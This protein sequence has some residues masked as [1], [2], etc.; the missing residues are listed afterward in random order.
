[1]NLDK[2]IKNY[3]FRI[4]ES[5]T[6]SH[7]EKFNKTDL[8][9]IKK[10]FSYGRCEFLLKSS[11]LFNKLPNDEQKK[12][13]NIVK[14]RN[15]NSLNIFNDFLILAKALTQKK[16]EFIPLKGIHLQ[17]LVYRNINLRPIRDIDLL[18][19][20]NDLEVFLSC[21]FS[22]G[23]R[24]KNIDLELNEFCNSD[25]HYDLPVLINDSGTHVETHLRI[26]DET[27]NSLIHCKKNQRKFSE[28]LNIS[29]MSYEDLLIHIA[30][31]ATI[32]NGFDN[33]VISIIDAVEILKNK[34]IDFQILF[35]NAEALGLTKNINLLLTIINNRFYSVDLSK[36]I[37]LEINDEMLDNYEDL[38]LYNHADD[39]S[40][41]LFNKKNKL[42]SFSKSAFIY[43]SGRK[44]IS[45]FFI[46]K[47]FLRISFGFIKTVFFLIFYR[48]YRIDALRVS[49]LYRFLEK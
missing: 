46:L 34:D 39:Y 8:K 43:E 38:I 2:H 10:V 29:F 26:I 48:K 49:N 22:L 20:E 9:T 28:Q 30:F 14:A 42:K 36:K 41:K 13:N 44:N 11:S 37:N 47:R 40:F 21:M 18:I 27:F 19:R 6:C 23:Y 24:F 1:M 3:I 25:Y 35:S 16:I 4:L 31:H 33:G 5:P 12:I 32:K 45:I 7:S 15:I 17:M